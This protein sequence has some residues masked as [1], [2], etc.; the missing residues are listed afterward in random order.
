MNIQNAFLS[1][2]R[3][4]KIRTR[5]SEGSHDMDLLVV[6]DAEDTIGRSSLLDHTLQT[7]ANREC[8]LSI[9]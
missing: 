4:D 5:G 8:K 9:E 7:R 1:P 3:Q 2:V 6:D